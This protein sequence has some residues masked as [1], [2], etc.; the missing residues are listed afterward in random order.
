MKVVKAILS[1]EAE[2][3]YKCLNQDFRNLHKFWISDSA[4]KLKV[5]DKLKPQKLKECC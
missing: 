5:F 2:E 4:Q 3:V 1:P